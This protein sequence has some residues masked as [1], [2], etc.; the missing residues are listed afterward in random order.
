MVSSALCRGSS[1]TRNTCLSQLI[2]IEA[3]IALLVVGMLEFC[4]FAF[5][6][7]FLFSQI[8]TTL[9]VEKACNPFLRTWSIEI[10][11]KLTIAATADD[12]EALGVIRQAKD[13]F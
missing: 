8:P 13:N 10:R 6:K 3:C 4:V 2:V 12:A 9:K 1:F 7:L 11:Q 5:S